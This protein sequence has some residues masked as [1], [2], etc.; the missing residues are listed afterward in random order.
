MHAVIIHSCLVRLVETFMGVFINSSCHL[1]SLTASSGSE[2][3]DVYLAIIDKGDV[4]ACLPNQE[5]LDEECGEGMR[6]I[7]W[8]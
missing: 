4:D 6:Y 3:S 5:A 7:M 2:V 8:S 1:L